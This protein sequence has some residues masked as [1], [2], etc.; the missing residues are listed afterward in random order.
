[1]VPGSAWQPQP[2]SRGVVVRTLESSQ[3]GHMEPAAL[4]PL[5]IQL[6]FIL[7]GH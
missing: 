6:C 7:W 5:S 4:G 2:Y 1:M 3:P